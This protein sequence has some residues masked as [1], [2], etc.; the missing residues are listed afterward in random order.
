M[1]TPLQCSIEGTNLVIRIGI[2]TLAWAAKEKNGGPID[3]RVRI[4][5]KSEL[6]KDVAN[7]LMREDELGNM[8]ISE[9]IDDAIKNAAE[10][11]S[12]AFAYP[13]N[14]PKS[15]IQPRALSRAHAILKGGQE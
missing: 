12:V 11:G 4:A 10:H 14:R 2:G 5:D 8:P 1:N 15:L 13:R 3:N 7:E 6:A 9:L